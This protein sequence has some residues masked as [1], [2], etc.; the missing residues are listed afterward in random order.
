MRDDHPS[1]AQRDSFVLKP[2]HSNNCFGDDARSSAAQRY[3]SVV[4]LRPA[5]APTAVG[6][7]R[8][9]KGAERWARVLRKPG[10]RTNASGRLPS[11]FV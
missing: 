8:P 10:Q 2:A 9:G 7:I 11:A 5:G 3:P 1:A 6:A 4:T